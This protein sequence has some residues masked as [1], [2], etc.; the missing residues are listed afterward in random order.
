MQLA[1]FSFKLSLKDSPKCCDH[2]F[3]RWHLPFEKGHINIQVAMVYYIYYVGLDDLTE[4]L[5]VN[6]EACI[7][8]GLAL[9]GHKQLKVMSMKVLIGAFTKYQL[10]L[11]IGPVFSKKTVRCIE[12]LPSGDVNH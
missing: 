11:L 8:V 3:N 4:F 1:G 6:N 5:K 12:C 7:G 2:V 10:I 9:Y